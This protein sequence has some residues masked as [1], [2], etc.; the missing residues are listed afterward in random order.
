MIL[1]PG[2]KSLGHVGEVDLEFE[3]FLPPP[4][5]SWGYAAA[6]LII[7]CPLHASY[8]IL[9]PYAA[10]LPACIADGIT[11]SQRYPRPLP[12]PSDYGH[13]GR[14]GRTNHQRF[15]GCQARC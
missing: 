12:N 6:H 5:E 15:A 4:P 1:F 8:L 3:I 13:E 2:D 9:Q 14:L 10:N 11:V 7:V